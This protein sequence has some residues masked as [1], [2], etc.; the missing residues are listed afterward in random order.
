MS[1]RDATDSF[2]QKCAPSA[3]Y[4]SKENLPT[5]PFDGRVVWTACGVEASGMTVLGKQSATTAGQLLTFAVNDIK[6]IQ[7]VAV[8][9]T[10]PGGY[11]VR[12]A[13]SSLRSRAWRSH[14]SRLTPLG[15][16]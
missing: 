8:V 13:R 4:H 14:S 12:G 9:A 10:R 3:V 7:T 16:R 1:S 6:D 11:K 5:E 2:F 15:R